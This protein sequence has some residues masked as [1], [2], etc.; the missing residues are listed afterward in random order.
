MKYVIFTSETDTNQD[1]NVRWKLEISRKNTK[2]DVVNR[3][4]KKEK[5]K[6]GKK[7]LEEKQ[8]RK[9]RGNNILE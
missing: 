1:R 5:E 3:K 8:K 9:T 4:A 7:R 2:R 6:G